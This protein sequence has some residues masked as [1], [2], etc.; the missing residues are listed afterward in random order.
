VVTSTIPGRTARAEA[1][2][3]ILLFLDSTTGSN[4]IMVRYLLK[5]MNTFLR[6]G[7][8]EEKCYFLLCGGR[9]GK[10]MRCN[11]SAVT[12]LILCFYRYTR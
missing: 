4:T 7:N 12:F 1:K 9:N 6:Q 2:Q 8:I 3:E 5:V 10:G 11:L